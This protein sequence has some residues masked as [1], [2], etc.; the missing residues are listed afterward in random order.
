MTFISEFELLVWDFLHS[1][2][3]HPVVVDILVQ[4]LLELLVAGPF[5][6]PAPLFKGTRDPRGTNFVSPGPACSN[7]PEV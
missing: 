5:K 1:Q 6:T 2:E 7:V 4:K 3:E